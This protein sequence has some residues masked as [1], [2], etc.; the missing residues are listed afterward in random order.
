MGAGG[1]GPQGLVDPATS[2][3]M[4]ALAGGPYGAAK[5]PEGLEMDFVKGTAAILADA[6]GHTL[7]V[8]LWVAVG[9]CGWLWVAVGGCGPRAGAGVAR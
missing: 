2:P 9:G 3:T 8:R 4:A 5:S 7:K 6:P 1:P